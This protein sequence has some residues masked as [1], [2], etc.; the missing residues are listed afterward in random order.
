MVG[1]AELRRVGDE[2]GV[3]RLTT[4]HI[5]LALVAH[6]LIRIKVGKPRIVLVAV[7]LS[8]TRGVQ[9]SSVVASSA[10]PFWR[11]LVRLLS[12]RGHGAAAE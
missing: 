6:T 4:F 3:W 12:G 11:S 8:V 2:E 5:V 10:A 9:C 7:E 1:S